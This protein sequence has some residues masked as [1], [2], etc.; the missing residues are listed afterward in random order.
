MTA[1][2]ILQTQDSR[3]VGL[4]GAWARS[5]SVALDVIRVDRWPKL[6]DPTDYAFAVALGSD[7]S[8][9]EA[10]PEWVANEVRWLRR[11]NELGVPVLGICFGAQALAVALGGSVQRSPTS[12]FEWLELETR[13]PARVPTGPWLALHGDAITVPQDAVELARNEFGPLAF[14]VGRNLALQFHPEAT[15]TLLVRWLADDG[16]SAPTRASILAQAR[17]HSRAATCAA[18]QLFDAF[19]ARAGLRSMAVGRPAT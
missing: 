11:A 10:W 16:E 5:R 13:E 3:P 19:A 6:P 2:L 7:A 12:E 18:V 15:P 14:T 8:L 4:L 17:Q 9:A 1:A